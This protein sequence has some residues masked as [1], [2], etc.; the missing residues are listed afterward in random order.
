VNH[1]ANIDLLST[2][3]RSWE[4]RFDAFVV[5]IGF[6]TLAIAVGRPPSTLEAARLVAA[7][8]FATCPDIIYQGCGSIEEYARALRDD[9]SWEFWWD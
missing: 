7:E 1:F 5:G 3:L 4:E 6:D 8:H 2:V 9:D